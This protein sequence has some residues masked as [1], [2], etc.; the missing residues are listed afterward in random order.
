MQWRVFTLD[1]NK[2]KI[3]AEWSSR[4]VQK[5]KSK[6]VKKKKKKFSCFSVL[7]VQI[8][9][10][11]YSA[12]HV[13]MVYEYS[14]AVWAFGS[15]WRCTQLQI[16]TKEMHD[17]TF[18]IKSHSVGGGG[19]PEKRIAQDIPKWVQHFIR[20]NYPVKPCCTIDDKRWMIEYYQGEGNLRTVISFY[21]SLLNKSVLERQKKNPA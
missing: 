12:A 5:S 21:V 20:M 7:I 16:H 11:H 2:W 1:R 8:Y 3:M 9:M 18:K 17:D 19:F 6:C 14:W 4:K 15:Y 13:Q 10:C